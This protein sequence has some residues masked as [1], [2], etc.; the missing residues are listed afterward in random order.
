[1]SKILIVHN[2]TL[3]NV[4]FRII[5]KPITECDSYEEVLEA[6]STEKAEAGVLPSFV[7]G[8][9]MIDLYYKLNLRVPYQLDLKVPVKMLYNP[10]LFQNDTVYVQC[11]NT[12]LSVVFEMYIRK[13]KEFVQVSIFYSPSYPSKH[14][15]LFKR[16]NNVEDVETTLYRRHVLTG[17]K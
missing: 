5:T 12:Y 1:M 8:A 6:V 9:M 13:Y 7:A 10:R 11:A 14:A 3:K 16:F 17:M 15:M 2:V 4:T